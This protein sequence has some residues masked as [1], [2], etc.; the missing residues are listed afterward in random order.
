MLE[1]DRAFSQ[2][3]RVEASE[4]VGGRPVVL[5]DAHELFVVVYLTPPLRCLSQPRNSLASRRAR[6]QAKNSLSHGLT[7]RPVTVD[8]TQ[9]IECVCHRHATI[10]RYQIGLVNS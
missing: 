1:I 3:T 6:L 7:S 4:H 9:L 8:G 5:G 10:E 2:P